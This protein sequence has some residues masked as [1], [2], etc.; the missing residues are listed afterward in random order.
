MNKTQW[1]KRSSSAVRKH[2][3]FF[4][5]SKPTCCSSMMWHSGVFNLFCIDSLHPLTFM[6]N[7]HECEMSS[8]EAAEEAFY[9]CFFNGRPLTQRAWAGPL[10][11]LL[12]LGLQG[13][14][15]KEQHLDPSLPSGLIV[16]VPPGYKIW[17]LIWLFY[18][19]QV[20]QINTNMFQ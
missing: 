10:G 13:N 17:M 9:C 7:G 6:H 2:Q 19:V 8:P 3:P 16:S 15:H 14:F 1:N 5:F 11:L 12:C 20:R 18:S 4:I